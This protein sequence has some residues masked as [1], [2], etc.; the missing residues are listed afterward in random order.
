MINLL[1]PEAIIT[2]NFFYARVLTA[3]EA[4]VSRLNDSQLYSEDCA[5]IPLP[6][7]KKLLFYD[8]RSLLNQNN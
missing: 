7:L 8:I 6:D 3:Y 2:L 1:K 5:A 4:C